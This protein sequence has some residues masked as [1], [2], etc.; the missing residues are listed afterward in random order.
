MRRQ[1]RVYLPE[2]RPDSGSLAVMSL[3]HFQRESFFRYPH[4]HPAWA[5]VYFET[6]VT[7]LLGGAKRQIAGG[8]A[9]VFPPS[10]PLFYGHEKGFRQRFLCVRGPELAPWAKAHRLPIE[11]PIP[12][13]S[14][15]LFAD[16]LHRID[17][18]LSAH[19]NF[20]P[21]LVRNLVENLVIELARASEPRPAP[22]IDERLLRARRHLETHYPEPLRLSDL[23]AVAGLSASRFSRAFHA[24][25]GA[26]PIELL[27]QVRLEAAREKLLSSDLP[28]REIA[29]EVGFP[30][31]L[32]FS[33]VFTQ[34]QGQ[35]PRA[36][37]R[38]K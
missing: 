12:C 14:A 11:A 37:R 10:R 34:R 7:V 2:N 33:K 6:A 28:I 8:H 16:A 17:G 24:A 21:A 3:G 15:A 23:A 27:I 26:S 13:P 35:G 9:V 18:E 32:H 1:Y 4:G 36:F 22:A 30:D 29:F 19:E 25:F 38:G 20:H 31:A 5:F